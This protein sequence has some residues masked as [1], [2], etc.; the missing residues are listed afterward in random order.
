MLQ[1]ARLDGQLF[2]KNDEL[3][4]DEEQLELKYQGINQKYRDA[5]IDLKVCAFTYHTCMILKASSIAF[6]N[7]AQRLD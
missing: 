7:G 5:L 1:C 2:S 3:Q 6:G 4:R